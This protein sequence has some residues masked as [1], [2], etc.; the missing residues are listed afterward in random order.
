MIGWPAAAADPAA[1]LP[2]PVVLP[3]AGA[4]LAPLVARRRARAGLAVALI[5]LAA[6]T[7]VLLILAPATFGGHLTAQT[8]GHW[9]ALH[10]T[11]LGVTFLADPFGLTVALL[12][13]LVGMVLIVATLSELSGLGAKELG[14]YACLFQ[15]LVAGLIGA[16]L[17]ADSIDLFVWFE[18]VALA[19]YGLCGFFL[20]RPPALEAALKMMVLTNVAAFCVFVGAAML[21]TRTGALSFGQLHEALA[22][23]A[24]D[25]PPVVM[26]ALALLVAGFAVKAGLMPFHG[27]LAD[28]QMTAPGPASAL[29]AGLMD[30]LG[31]LCIVRFA[32]DVYDRAGG[33]VLTWLAVVGAISAVLGALLALAQDDLKRLLAYDTV[34]QMG[35][36]AAGFS[37][38]STAGVAGAVYHLVDHGLFK[39][40]LFL[41]AG[42]I[43]HSTGR[44]RLSELGG[45]ARRRPVLAGAFILGCAAIAGVPPMNGYVSVG[46]IHDALRDGH[47]VLYATMLLAQVLTVAALGRATYLAFLRRPAGEQHRLSRPRPAM[48]TAFG[49]L[50]AGCVA[51]GVVPDAVLRHVAGP[52]ATGLLSA[53]HYARAALTG[54]GQLPEAD[55][56]FSY[57]APSELVTMASTVVAGLLVAIWYVRRAREPALVRALRRVHTGSVNDYVAFAAVG[58]VGTLAVLVW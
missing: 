23:S 5:A 34:S 44:I 41:C 50:A 13:S 56:S 35:V 1:L 12:S 16:S 38:A 19:S 2:V 31:I 25:P 17:T 26:I 15:L 6:A 28:A 55:V 27:W 4:V 42:S 37:S 48:T 57:F 39:T 11:V 10:G 58:L 46:L 45:L 18:V 30:N 7:A 29:F 47:P 49:L 20:E 54:H 43:L 52:A 51:F 36:L 9:G 8:L 33:A 22:R 21:Y 40:L 53:G 14:G 24:A 32:F 3:L